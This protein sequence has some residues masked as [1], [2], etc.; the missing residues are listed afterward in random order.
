MD[1]EMEALLKLLPNLNKINIKGEELFEE[2]DCRLDHLYAGVKS[3]NNLKVL[4]CKDFSTDEA[5]D[6]DRTKI[7]MLI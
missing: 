6:F 5:Y 3:L 4:T 1:E 7:I 2:F